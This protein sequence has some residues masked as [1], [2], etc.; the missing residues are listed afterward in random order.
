MS[1]ETMKLPDEMQNENGLQRPLNEEEKKQIK[2]LD[3]VVDEV[4]STQKE[5]E[6]EYDKE[7]S[8]DVP[9]EKL[10]LEGNKEEAL[11][12]LNEF[13]IKKAEV[14]KKIREQGDSPQLQGER[15]QLMEIIKRQKEANDEMFQ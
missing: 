7:V 14:E 8:F 10:N 12:K 15:N 5:V 2:E 9:V 13:N 4:L 11:K 6:V 3:V 1:E